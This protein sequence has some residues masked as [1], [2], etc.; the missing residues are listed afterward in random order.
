MVQAH[1]AT[2]GESVNG[3]I[4]RAVSETME[5]DSLRNRRKGPRI[6]DRDRGGIY[7]YPLKLSKQ[8]RRPQKLPGKR[9]LPL[10][11]VRLIALFPE[12]ST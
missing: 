10:Y 11:P 3:F 8:L 12:K 7:L 4:G 2:N 1:A 6:G 9:F 5:R